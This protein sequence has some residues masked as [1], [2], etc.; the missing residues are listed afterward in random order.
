MK[1]IILIPLTLLFINTIFPQPCIEDVRALVD[2]F[3]EVEGVEMITS[4]GKGYV[5][6][7]NGG[8]TLYFFSALTGLKTIQN[9][10]LGFPIGVSANG[11]FVVIR[12][13]NEEWYRWETSS[14]ILLPMPFP[15]NTFASENPVKVTNNGSV[16]ANLRSEERRLGKCL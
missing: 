3:I 11:Q 6:Y 15:G 7:D 14:G 16:F 2:E 1:R 12:G 8:Q 5:G 10:V 9:T 4:D 13:S